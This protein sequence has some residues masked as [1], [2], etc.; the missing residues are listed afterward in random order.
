MISGFPVVCFPM[1]IGESRKDRLGKAQRAEI[2][3]RALAGEC[4]AQIAREF[5]VTRAYVSLLKAYVLHP[6]RYILKAQK[7][8]SRKLTP[9]ELHS[10]QSALANGTPETYKLR[11]AASSWSLDHAF[12]LA[13][14]LFKK[15]PSLR[16][17]K[18]CLAPHLRGTSQGVRRRRSSR[19]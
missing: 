8:F 19:S 16:V 2:T 4:G 3:R 6:E 10:F 12:K 18:Q 13:M 9:D 14:K 11:P 17:V 1:H 5:G 15:R 7:N